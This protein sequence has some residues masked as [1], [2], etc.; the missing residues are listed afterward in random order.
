MDIPNIAA[1]SYFQAISR[2]FHSWELNTTAAWTLC[3]VFGAIGLSVGVYFLHR[4]FASS[5]WAKSAFSVDKPEEIQT[6]FLKA[7]EDRSKFEMSFSPQSK[8]HAACT[9][10]GFTPQELAL[11]LPGHIA[12]GPDWIG[13]ELCIFFSIP[14]SR[15]R[16]VYYTFSAQIHS[17]AEHG[18]FYRL[19]LPLPSRI[20][21]QQK[22]RHLRLDIGIQDVSHLA[23]WRNTV[24]VAEGLD[25][26]PKDLGEPLFFK[27]NGAE[28]NTRF[29]R[30][31]NISG[32]GLRFTIAGEGLRRLGLNLQ[33][34]QQLLLS[35][36]LPLQ[37][38][39][40]GVAETLACRLRNRSEDFISREV[41]I[42]LEFE[43]VARTDPKRPETL[44]WLRVDPDFGVE[45]IA[46]WVFQQ[47]LKWYRDKGI[48]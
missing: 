26:D 32:G 25:F 10:V 6:I 45:P 1:S 37:G 39:S 36:E 30:L 19:H 28:K 27:K 31:V 21:Q 7:L 40:P 48:C 43:Y 18:E 17:I 3:G 13:R 23:L 24:P 12:P 38:K 44:R 34:S 46:Q 9:L 42:G 8:P 4:R 35:L 16:R 41:D 2:S 22:R 5:P 33:R 20:E 15:K 11:E 47:H 29:L 14:W